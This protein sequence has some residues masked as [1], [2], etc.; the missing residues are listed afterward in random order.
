MRSVR[1]FSV[2]K[3]L[4]NGQLTSAPFFKANSI[5]STLASAAGY[6]ARKV[7][8]HIYIW[9]MGIDVA[10]STIF[11]LDFGT[12][13]TVWYICAVH[14]I[15]DSWQKSKFYLYVFYIISFIDGRLSFKAVTKIRTLRYWHVQ[16]NEQ[17]YF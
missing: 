8:G 11:L 12:V 9:I 3:E 1:T 10:F 16:I 15:P 13:P 4:S 2:F 17:H 7:S 6:Q 14:F 5:L